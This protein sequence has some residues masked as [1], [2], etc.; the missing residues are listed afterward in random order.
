[1]LGAGWRAKKISL[2]QGWGRTACKH[3]MGTGD[4]V[5]EPEKENSRGGSAIGLR[6]RHL[7][8]DEFTAYRNNRMCVEQIR[9]GLHRILN[10]NGAR[11]GCIEQSR[12]RGVEPRYF[13]P[14][15]KS[16]VT[17]L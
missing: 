7:G 17:S 13:G 11:R 2:G 8:L 10:D 12:D 4:A 9:S 5:S 14:N 6:T 3:D 15:D 1:M 16:W